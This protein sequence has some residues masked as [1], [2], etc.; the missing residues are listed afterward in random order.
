MYNNIL[1]ITYGIK[2]TTK[3]ILIITIN[4]YLYRRMTPKTLAT[5]KRSN[6][7]QRKTSTYMGPEPLPFE[8]IRVGLKEELDLAVISI[9]EVPYWE[10][11]NA[12]AY[13]S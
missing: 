2:A 13:R 10:R 12:I 1:N 5:V 4:S 8:E 6:T 9:V 7:I 3:T 11:K